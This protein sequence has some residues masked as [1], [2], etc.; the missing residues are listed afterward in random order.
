MLTKLYQYYYPHPPLS[1]LLFVGLLHEFIPWAPG[2]EP[3]L[4]IY[5]YLR[6]VHARL[7]TIWTCLRVGVRILLYNYMDKLRFDTC[8]LV[9][10]C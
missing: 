6:W 4:K 9:Y 7:H 3:D 8:P 5:S 2:N 1:L 10:M